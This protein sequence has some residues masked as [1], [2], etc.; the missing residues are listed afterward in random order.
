[1]K[2][3]GLVTGSRAEYGIMKNLISKFY[4]DDEID[5]QIIATAMHLE[6]KYG[7]TYKV[8]ESDGFEISYKIPLNLI[9][10]S[11]EV[12]SKSLSILTLKLSQIFSHEEYDLIIILGDRYEMLPVVNTALIYNIPVC[13]L[14]GGEKTLGNFDEYI[15]HAITKM[16]HLHLV[17]TDEYRNRIIQMGELPEMI[18]NT[19]SLG[20]EN[21]VSSQKLSKSQLSQELKIDLPENYFVILF[22]PETLLGEHEA[23][24]QIKELLSALHKVNSSYVFIG[25]N[26]DTGSDLI[27]DEIKKFV[28]KHDSTY[29]FT[30]LKTQVYH[31]LVQNS[32][33]LVGNSS[34]G[35]IEIPSLNVPT[36]NIG[37]RQKGR[38]QGTSIVNVSI[39][40]KEIIDGIN[41][42]NTI[43]EFYN[44]YMKN[45]SSQIAYEAI[46]R[47]LENGISTY[48][49]FN[50][51]E[52]SYEK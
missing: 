5:L 22:H 48:K 2:K 31:S 7:F 47:A 24:D 10:T 18:V 14:H 44:P 33:G 16:S 9:D 41:K 43:K 21:V 12:I 34:S 46:K 15:R 30:S 17:S 50:D 27:M 51:L 42:L 38:L 28:N 8:I 26:S 37:D 13:H 29:L 4:N 25:S 23:I 45:N 1:M 49:E 32:L 39:N 11:K 6:E 3:I 19:G 52:F 35:I 20:V 40:E 36:L